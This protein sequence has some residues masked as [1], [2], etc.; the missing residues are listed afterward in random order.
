MKEG[1]ERL[2]QDLLTI[3]WAS[4]S[5]I[6]VFPRNDIISQGT[7]D[8]PTDYG[9]DYYRLSIYITPQ[10]TKSDCNCKKKQPCHYQELSEKNL[11]WN[12]ADRGR[13]IWTG[14]RHHICTRIGD[15]VVERLA[16]VTESWLSW[17]HI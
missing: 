16:P 17:V 15:V 2:V 12:P 10:A 6:R 1:T 4:L 9:D 13:P 11:P 3:A 5:A 14:C 7:N 8:R